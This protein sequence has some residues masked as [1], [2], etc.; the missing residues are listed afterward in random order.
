MYKCYISVCLG[1]GCFHVLPIVN[2]AVMSI[3]VCASFQFIVLFRYIPRSGIAGSYGDSSFS[4]LRNLHTVLWRRHW[5]PT[6]DLL[7]EKSHGRK[8]LVGCGPWGR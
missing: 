7:P 2:S 1:L 8:S 4:F 3:E 6:P 5:H